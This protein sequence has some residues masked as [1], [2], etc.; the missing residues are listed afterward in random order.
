MWLTITSLRG[1]RIPSFTNIREKMASP[2]R[3]RR[4]I[5]K[6]KKRKRCVYLFNK[7]TR[8]TSL[9]TN[10]F[11]RY[12]YLSQGER[13]KKKEEMIIPYAMKSQIS[14]GAKRIKTRSSKYIFPRQ[15]KIRKHS[16]KLRIEQMKL[17]K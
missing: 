12:F 14:E 15:S 13:E 5:K 3:I 17:M 11:H 16:E 10:D 9:R 4:D 1:P 2:G 8:S 7:D 6:K